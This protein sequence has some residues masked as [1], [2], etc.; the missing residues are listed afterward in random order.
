MPW[1]LAIIILNV[2]CSQFYPGFV[3]A[4]FALSNYSAWIICC[5]GFNVGLRNRNRVW[6]AFLL[7]WGYLELSSVMGYYP[8]QGMA[9]LLNALITS[10][11]AGYYLSL[12]A[13][14]TE[15][16]LRRI[17]FAVACASM[18]IGY[19]YMKHG[20][21]MSMEVAGVSRM[22]FDSNT[23]DQDVKSNVNYTA[24][25]MCTVLPFLLVSVMT[26]AHTRFEKIVRTI[27]AIGLIMCTMVLFRTGSRSGGLSLLP[28]AWYFFFSTKDK[29]KK[30]NRRAMFITVGILSVCAV[31]WTMRGAS[32]IRLFKIFSNTNAEY[33]L[34]ANEITSGRLDWWIGE[35]KAMS[36]AQVLLGSGFKDTA[37][38]ERARVGLANYHSMYV[39]VFMQSGLLGLILFFTAIMMGFRVA[40]RKGDRGR[41]AMMFLGVW[42]VTGLGE[43]WG[44][45]GGAI[46]VLA[47]FGM[48]LC[49]DMKV[50]NS[51]L[52]NN[53]E[54]QRF[55][56]L[57]YW[58]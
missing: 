23:L 32:E 58:G 47:G 6:T 55:S 34:T 11:C 26:M 46:A 56:H 44:M 36:P 39:F 9:S 22:N 43:A 31:A 48:G 16:S 38:N 12:W 29:L 1:A 17:N 51:E 5:D 13:C 21:F 30:R 33:K 42:A 45:I 28:L 8:F 15:G 2:S 54:R 18:I 37:L 50:R 52:M 10:F 20:A 3:H 40:G 49:T 25:C 57:P 4:V 19:L 53:N 27:S 24:L 14:R 35:Y 7:F 41:M